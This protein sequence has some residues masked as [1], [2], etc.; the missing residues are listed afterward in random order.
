MADPSK[1]SLQ[2]DLPPPTQRTPSSHLVP[3]LLVLPSSHPLCSAVI[4]HLVSSKWPL[5]ALTQLFPPFVCLRPK[6]GCQSR[7][8]WIYLAVLAKA[9][10]ESESKSF[11]SFTLLLRR[12]IPFQVLHRL[13]TDLF[14]LCGCPFLNHCPLSQLPLPRVSIATQSFSYSPLYSLLFALRFT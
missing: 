3:H 12:S 13:T 1:H 14:I 10:L 6:H 11:F 8:R 7:T 2:P 5:T 4:S 9:L